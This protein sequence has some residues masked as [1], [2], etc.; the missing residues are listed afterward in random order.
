MDTDGGK[1]EKLS[2]KEFN[3]KAQSSKG[4]KVF[5]HSSLLPLE[6]NSLDRFVFAWLR[7]VGMDTDGGHVKRET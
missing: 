2:A 7:P 5:K 4:A 1:T 3:A 6:R